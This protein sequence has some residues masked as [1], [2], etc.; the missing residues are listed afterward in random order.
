MLDCTVMTAL[1]LRFRTDSRPDLPLGTGVHALA[2]R[3]GT[4]IPVPSDE[5]W[6]LQLRHD[7]RGLWL[8]VAA[9]A[10]SVHVNGRPVRRLALLR[11]GDSLHVD[12]H[13]LL[14]VAPREA[15]P[16]PAP[17][18]E[19]RASGSLRVVLRALGGD[20]HGRCF[21]LKHPLWIG[22]ANEGDLVLSGHGI[23]ARH[24]CVE[25]RGEQV[26]LDHAQGDVWLNGEPVRQAVL[27]PGDQLVFGN[28]HRFVLEGPPLSTPALDVP[29]LASLSASTEPPSAPHWS[30]RVPW[31]LIAALGLAGLLWALLV[32]GAR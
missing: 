12:G 32:F 17:T 11:A 7:R 9:A 22:S 5:D 24:A 20:H 19:H 23:L 26:V 4:L 31:L 8:M 10:P 25:V 18:P 29:L 13:E 28:R 14:L 1:L 27:Q 3:E 15:A 30:Q 16:L 2:C 21:P 6:T